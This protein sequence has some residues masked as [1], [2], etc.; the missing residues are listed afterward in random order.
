[1]DNIPVKLIN[2]MT[3]LT[4]TKYLCHKRL[5]ILSVCRNHNPVLP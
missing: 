1:V 3:W 5:R 2:I 4:V